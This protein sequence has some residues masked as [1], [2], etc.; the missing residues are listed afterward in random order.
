MATVNCNDYKIGDR[1]YELHRQLC[2]AVK[3]TKIGAVLGEVKHWDGEM[4][5]R[6]YL[7]DF[8]RLVHKNQHMHIDQENEIKEYK[9]AMV[10]RSKIKILSFIFTTV[11]IKCF[12]CIS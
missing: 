7:H 1:K 9:V 6:Y 4:L 3:L 12:R 2:E 8:V 5:Y 11:I 10:V